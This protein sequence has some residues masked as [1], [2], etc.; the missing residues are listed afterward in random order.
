[1]MDSILGACSICGGDVVVPGIWYG[2]MPP[3]PTCSSCG[4][5]KARPVVSMDPPRQI[6]VSTGTSSA[7]V[8]WIRTGPSTS[9]G[10]GNGSKS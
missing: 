3:T 8:E 10:I 2:V 7:G 5:M 1:M 4:A 6:Y 9:S